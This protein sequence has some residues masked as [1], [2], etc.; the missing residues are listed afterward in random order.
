[1]PCGGHNTPVT[2]LQNLTVKSILF[3]QDLGLWFIWRRLSTK[4]IIMYG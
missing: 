1:M 3:N 2:G 4:L